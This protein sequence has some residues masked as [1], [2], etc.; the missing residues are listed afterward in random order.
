MTQRTGKT[1]Q[2]G[3]F[4]SVLSLLG[5]LAALAVIDA[6]AIAFIYAMAASDLLLGAIVLAVVTLVVN[7]VFLVDRLYPLRWI[8]PGV[9]LMVLLVVYPALYTGYIATTNYGQGHILSKAQVV[10]R[11]ANRFYTPAEDAQL[12]W[13][14]YRA[15]SGEFILWLTDAEGNEFLARPGEG[16][17]PVVPNDPRFGAADP[18]DGLPTTIDGFRKLSR[19]QSV[20]FLTALS[21]LTVRGEIEGQE[22][23]LRIR[24]LDAAEL[25]IQRFVYDPARDVVLDQQ[26]GTEYAAVEGFFQAEDGS[27]LTPGFVD[28]VGARNFLRAVTDSNIRGPFVGVFIWTFVFAAATVALAFAVGLALALVM[29]DQRLPVKGLLRTLIIIPYTIPGFISILIWVGLLNPLYG[30]VN[31]ALREFAGIS[32]LWFSDP[33][34]AKV[35]ILLVNTWLGY[36]Y[37]MI[38]TLGA[39]QSIP[40]DLYEAARIDGA[41]AYQQ[42]RRITLPLLLV[43]IA[44]LLIGAFAFNFNNFTLIELMTA[45]GPPTPGANSPAGQ[46]DILISYSYRLAFAAGRGNDYAFAAAISVFIFM[47][48]AAITIFNFRLSRRL[49]NLI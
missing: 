46:T 24:S 47:I 2:G 7:V 27:R 42:F 25:A 14:A 4:P 28:S 22:A 16:I 31:G 34:L 1:S 20:R 35:A 17:T 36:P 19:G 9:L 21:N 32:P 38:V 44:P 30:P 18:E 23:Q 49:E 6:V 41:S 48:V 33:D 15:D 29:N 3:V 40:G 11:L 8:S 10:D 37:M 26:T 43:A 45:G 39:L 12:D 13:R 5:R